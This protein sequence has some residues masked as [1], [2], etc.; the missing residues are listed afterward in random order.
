MFSA[1]KSK[2]K[3]PKPF[4]REDGGRIDQE[5]GAG[6]RASDNPDDS[7][8]K[9]QATP[10]PHSEEPKENHAQGISLKKIHVNIST[11][12]SRNLT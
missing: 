5:K 1:S 2:R 4:D 3:F 10:R 11:Y 12:L 7:P 8:Y 6:D 9:H